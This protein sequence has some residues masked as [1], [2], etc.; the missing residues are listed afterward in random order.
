M[1][2]FGKNRRG[3]PEC[4]TEPRVRTTPTKAERRLDARI[5]SYNNALKTMMRPGPNPDGYH[6]P[7]SLQSS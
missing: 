6:R 3:A 5:Q 2:L 4:W 7:G 1:K